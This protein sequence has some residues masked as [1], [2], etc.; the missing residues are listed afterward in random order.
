LVLNKYNSAYDLNYG[1][2]SLEDFDDWD[3]GFALSLIPDIKTYSKE[4]YMDILIAWTALKGM[5]NQL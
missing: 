2:M 4:L 3:E 1:S 5:M